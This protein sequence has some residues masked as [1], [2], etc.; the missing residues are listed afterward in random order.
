MA[1]VVR[2]GVVARARRPEA[3]GDVAQGVARLVVAHHDEHPR[4]R[5]LCARRVGGRF[6][7]PFDVAV[8]H[9]LVAEVATR[10]LLQHDVEEVAHDFRR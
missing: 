7:D 10:P 5:V 6:E 2:L 1:F 4:L 8:G 9:R 3:A